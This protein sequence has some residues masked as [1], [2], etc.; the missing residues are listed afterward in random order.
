LHQPNVSE[1]DIE[2][3]AALSLSATGS[4]QDQNFDKDNPISDEYDPNES[5]PRMKVIRVQM[6]MIRMKVIR[7]QMKMIRMKVVQGRMKM[8]HV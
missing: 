6:K 5:D 8:I 1:Q 7:V 4:H 2:N 3:H